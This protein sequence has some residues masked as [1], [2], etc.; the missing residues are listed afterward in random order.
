MTSQGD[1]FIERELEY[2]DRP[3]PTQEHVEQVVEVMRNAMFELRDL[4][5]PCFL[6][7]FAPGDYTVHGMY[8]ASAQP[9][10][11]IMTLVGPADGVVDLWRQAARASRT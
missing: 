4:G 3:M 10:R 5:Y 7:V 2:Q 6:H 1:D 11:H 9:E 8:G